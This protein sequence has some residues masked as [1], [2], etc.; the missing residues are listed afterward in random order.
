MKRNLPTI[1]PILYISKT[2]ANGEHPIMLRVCY[3]GKRL[4]KSIGISCNLSEW[5][6]DKKRVKGSRA[7]SLN[8]IIIR[9]LTKANDYVLSLEGKDDYAASTIIKHLSKPSP[10]QITLF[11]LFEE[12]IAFFRQ[13]KQS[14]NNAV[15]YRTLLNRI[16]KY[17]NNADLELFE[18]NSNW[19]SEFE[20][21]LRCHYC[22]NSIK[23]FFDCFKAIFNY[24]KR[25]EYV[26]ETPFV[27]FAFSKK[28]DT[29]TR[30]RALTLAEITKL[31]SYYYQRYGMLGV[32]DNNVLGE[33]DLKQY[34]V[35][36]KFKMKGQNKLTPIDA[37]QFSLALYLT[38]YLFQGLALVDI[39][40]LKLK[41]LHLLEVV[42]D[43]KY[44]R[45]SALK[46]VDYAEANK[47]K[48]LHYDILTYRTKTHRYIRIITECE[49]LRPYLNPF[50]SYFEDYDLLDD[51][52]MERYLFPIFDHNND[53][54][55]TKFCRMTY[56][57]YLVNANL[58]RIS[59]RLGM[60]PITFYSARH[61]YASQLYHANVPVG[62]IAQNMGRNPSDIQT[63]LKDFDTNNIIAANNKS[64]MVGQELFKKIAKEQENGRHND[65]REL[66]NINGDVEGLARYDAYLKWREEH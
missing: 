23:K 36:Q 13:E 24:A 15:G 48:V 39:A 35:N 37:E 1:T 22:D 33:H 55:E 27:N 21:Y 6:K 10:T 19:L 16:K 51:E 40:N 12:R 3:N 56:M 54:P 59:K 32:E 63:Y 11:T 31:M 26:K 8:T 28:L 65:I 44:Q 2:L 5:N 64:L 58:K 50:G 57:N 41:D 61:S 60:L 66:L 34:W 18:I 43:E 47:K 42:D 49:N 38:S 7:S 45:D 52:D 4:Y 14:H 53:S 29:H 25:K 20:E 30:K 46:G 9:E 62:L 17:T